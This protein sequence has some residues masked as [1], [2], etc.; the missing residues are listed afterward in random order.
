MLFTPTYNR[1]HLLS[2]LYD[3]IVMQQSRDFEWL[4]IDDGSSDNTKQIVNDFY[5]DA[6]F[7]IRYYKK[8]S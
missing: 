8:I 6:V 2:K 1:A 3:S 4:I 7:P 5:S